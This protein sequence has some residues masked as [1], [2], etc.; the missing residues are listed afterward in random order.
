MAGFSGEEQLRCLSQGNR[1]EYWYQV[2]E[3]KGN[4]IMNWDEVE[5][6]WKQMKGAAKEKWGKLTDDNLDKIAGNREKLV[7]RLQECYGLHKELAELQC[8]EWCHAAE[9]IMKKESS[10]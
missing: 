4:S 10:A 2:A 6:N 7:G 8:D 3:R 9:K 5:G 1:L